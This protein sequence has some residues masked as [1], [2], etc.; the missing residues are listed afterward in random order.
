MNIVLNGE[1]TPPILK[2]KHI[3]LRMAKL[4]DVEAIRAYRQDAN[5]CRYIRPPE[6]NEVIFNLVEQLT[7]PWLFTLG[8]WNGFVI[9]QAGDDNAIGEIVFNIEDWDCQRAEIGYRISNEMAG[10]G[11]CTQA[12]SLLINYLFNE[13]GFFKLVAKCDTRNIASYK[14]MEKLGFKREAYFKDHYLLGEEWT[15][16][17]DYGLLSSQYSP[18]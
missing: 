4:S 15:D 11:I 8:R 9:C 17:Y 3:Y 1:L 12:V 14:V 5:N 13:L 18:D 7:K 6:S 10:R 16:Q 2:N